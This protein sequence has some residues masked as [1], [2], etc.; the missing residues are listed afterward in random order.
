MS[1]GKYI[2]FICFNVRLV[3]VY[4]IYIYMYLEVIMDMIFNFCN[5]LGESYVECRFIVC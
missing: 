5:G 3:W 4:E 2:L 1:Y